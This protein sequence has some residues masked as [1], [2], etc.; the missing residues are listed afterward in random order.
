MF[1]L[2]IITA[3]KTAYEGEIESLIA[4]ATTGEVGILTDHHPFI[5]KL[6]LGS[7]K[8]IT[9]DKSE[10]TL[11]VS[12]G[13][14]EVNNNQATILAD[15]VE[16]ILEIEVEQAALA[17]KKAEELLKSTSDELQLE[18]LLEE[19]RIQTMRE[20]LANIAKYKK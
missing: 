11:F 14:L 15:M 1:H 5:A 6:G 18:K 13:Y 19:L 3:E 7:L 2:S 8:I 12:G 4:P 16:N 9:K 17:R 10:Q 20:R